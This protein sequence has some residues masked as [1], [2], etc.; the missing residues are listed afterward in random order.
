MAE[1][2]K[3]TGDNG[4]G[5]R[6]PPTLHQF[7]KGTSGNPKGRPKSKKSGSTDVS[8]LLDEP[9]RVTSGGKARD[10][11]PFEVGFRKLAQRALNGDLPA[12]LKFVKT[13]EEYGVIAPPPVEIVGGVIHAPKGVSCEEWLEEVAEWVPVDEK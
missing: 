4:V 8:A 10:M 7:P 6:R 13:C 12:I 5:Y 2:T 3:T 11:P 1:E 9:V